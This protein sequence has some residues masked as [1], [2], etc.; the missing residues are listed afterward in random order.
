MTLFRLGYVAM[1]VHLK[2]SSPSKTI[3]YKNFSSFA[4]QEAGINKLASVARTNI[5]NCLR[6]L[7]HNIAHD[8]RFFRLSSKLVPLATHEDLKGWN[9]IKDIKADLIE[10][11]AYATKNNMRIGFHPDHFVVLN[12]PKK[13]V[14]KVSLITLDYHYKLLKHMNIDQTHSCVLHLGGKYVNKED[15][16][17]R[18]VTNFGVVP[19]RIQKMIILENDDKTYNVEDILYVSQKLNIPL[20]FDLHHHLANHVNEDWTIYWEKILST[21]SHSPHPIKMHISSP[22]N[23]NN[24]RH[25]ADYIDPDMFIKFA[26]EVNES[27]PQIDCMIE[28]KMK[29][30]ALFRLVKDLQK[31]PDVEMVDQAS[32]TIK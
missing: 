23:D 21:W 7:K 11:G 32:F 27:T 20:V 28:A 12:S 16:L 29:D 9:Y 15:S 31:H 17:E 1:S 25:H 18:F 19:N 30:Q 5:Q 6:L 22:K 24:F 3:T 26:K 10:L 4:D 2:N 13:D 14:L 8:I